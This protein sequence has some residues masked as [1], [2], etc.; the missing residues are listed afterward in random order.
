[1]K[2]KIK[3][4]LWA[5]LLGLIFWQAASA[6]DPDPTLTQWTPVPPCDGIAKEK[7]NWYTDGISPPSGRY[8]SDPITIQLFD[9]SLGVLKRVDIT[10]TG[11]IDQNAIGENLED[12]ADSI[13]V[14]AMGDIRTTLLDG[15]TK[16]I[17]TPEQESESA[18]VGPAEA[19]AGYGDFSGTDSHTFALSDICEDATT[20]ITDPS[21]RKSVV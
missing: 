10:L 15:T 2:T 3:L 9:P 21:D 4:I 14:K 20:S 16:I 6:A 5:V 11:C 18:T 13:S 19:G 17:S 1:M 8:I 7:T 12:Y